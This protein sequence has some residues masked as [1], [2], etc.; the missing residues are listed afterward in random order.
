MAF[1]HKT[2]PLLPKEIFLTRVV[3][4]AFYSLGILS[5]SLFMGMWGYHF[6]GHLQWIDALVNASM[7][8][9]GMGPVDRIET[10]NG[11]LFESFYAL[12]SGVA[13]LTTAA[14]LFAP[15]IHR[16]LHSLHLDDEK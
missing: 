5:F 7:I 14:V 12:Y 8:L 15:I 16:F 6:F 2:A 3:R 11:K 4:F 1:E 9:T 10:T 13:F